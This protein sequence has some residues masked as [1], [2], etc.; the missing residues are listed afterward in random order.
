MTVLNIALDREVLMNFA[1]EVASN[2]FTGVS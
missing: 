1:S 2:A